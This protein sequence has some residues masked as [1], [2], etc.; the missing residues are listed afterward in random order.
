MVV[1]VAVGFVKYVADEIAY[2]QAIPSQPSPDLPPLLAFNLMPSL[3]L[4]VLAGVVMLAIFTIET[5][6]RGN[7]PNRPKGRS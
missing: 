1:G 6:M 3:S 4:G 2:I 5:R 7:R